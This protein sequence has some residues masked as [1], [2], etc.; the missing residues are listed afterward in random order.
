[1]KKWLLL[2]CVTPVTEKY[3]N[4]IKHYKVEKYILLLM[5]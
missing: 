2:M 3:T 1:M 4:I 5:Y